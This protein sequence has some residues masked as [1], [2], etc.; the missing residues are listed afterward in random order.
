MASHVFLTISKSNGKILDLDKLCHHSDYV[1][2][3]IWQKSQIACLLGYN[4]R[5][6]QIEKS[7]KNPRCFLFKKSIDPQLTFR[8]KTHP[9]L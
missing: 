1:G 2:L 8:V 3:L 5:Q 7:I 9:A 4:A 6:S